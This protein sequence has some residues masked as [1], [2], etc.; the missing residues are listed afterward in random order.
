MPGK[1]YVLTFIVSLEVAVPPD[2]GVTE[3]GDR[4]YVD[5]KGHPERLKVTAD[6]K[7]LIEVT[8]M[9]EAPLVPLFMV[10][11][12]GDADREK[13]GAAP[14]ATVK[15]RVAVWVNVPLVPVIDSA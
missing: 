6:L 7:P 1:V 9:V 8:V 5:Q 15:L 11:E 14:P 4:V 12:F 10:S 13:F 3:A 2:G